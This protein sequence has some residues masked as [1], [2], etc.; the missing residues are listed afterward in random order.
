MIVLAGIS[1]FEDDAHLGIKRLHT[2]RAKVTGGIEKQPVGAALEWSC[3][4]QQIARAPALIRGDGGKSRPIASRANFQR[5]GNARGGTAAR[6]VENV[7]GYAAQL[8][9][10]IPFAKRLPRASLARLSR[11]QLL[12][13]QAHDAP[14]LFRGDRQFRGG[15][16]LNT[17]LE[18]GK[19]LGGRL[20]R[21]ADDENV[22]EALPVSAVPFRQLSSSPLRSSAGSRTALR[23]TSGP[24]GAG[25]L[26]TRFAFRPVFRQSA[27]GSRRPPASLRGR[28]CARSRRLR[29]KAPRN[30][31]RAGAPPSLA[32]NATLRNRPA[33][34]REPRP[35]EGRSADR[36]P[37]P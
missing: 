11:H 9:R 37:F 4:G 20:A 26:R 5:H 24:K 15:I 1:H 17:L 10:K 6:N 23:P 28:G 22:S 14:L 7:S 12:Q 33:T 16:I 18:N 19:H 3:G 34:R 32:P 36:G 2:L 8:F 35:R 27:D 31:E 21:G 25:P 13:T 29:R 30:R